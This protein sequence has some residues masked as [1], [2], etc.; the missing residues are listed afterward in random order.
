MRARVVETKTEDE[1][2]DIGIAGRTAKL[3]PYGCHPARPAF[4]PQVQAQT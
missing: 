2:F 1:P 4:S 3:P